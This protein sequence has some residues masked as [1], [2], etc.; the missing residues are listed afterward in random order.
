[1]TIAIS[2]SSGP[3][4]GRI[5]GYGRNAAASYEQHITDIIHSC[6]Y[7]PERDALAQNTHW[8]NNAFGFATDDPGWQVPIK[9]KD[10]DIRDAFDVNAD[11]E[12]DSVERAAALI[13]FDH[14]KP[15]I[16]E[17]LLKANVDDALSMSLTNWMQYSQHSWYEQ[18]EPRLKMGMQWLGKNYP[19]VKNWIDQKYIKTDKLPAQWREAFAEFPETILDG[20]VTVDEEYMA[21]LAALVFPSI[22]RKILTKLI[23]DTFKKPTGAPNLYAAYDTFRQAQMAENASS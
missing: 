12:I 21:F 2:G 6:R 1:M 11:G 15:H 7:S 9:V 10:Q 17:A 3:Y 16:L 4:T 20:Q 19:F 8:L 5:G 22:T 13:F 18:I 14:P 23:Y